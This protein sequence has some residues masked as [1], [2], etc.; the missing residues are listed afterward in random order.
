MTSPLRTRTRLGAAR[1]ANGAKAE[2]LEAL[3]D[4]LEDLILAE[5]FRGLTVDLMAAKLQCSKTTLYAIAPSKEQLVL[6]I[7]KRFFRKA[8]GDVDA[9]VAGI[10]DP[11]TRI[12][13]YLDSVGEAMRKMSAACFEDMIRSEATRDVYDKN[14]RA[15]AEFVRGAIRE[16]IKRKVFRSV[17]A[18]FVGE[19]VSLLIEAIQ[20]GSLLDRTGLSSGDAF[21]E[22]SAVVVGALAAP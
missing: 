22:L 14:S 19:A 10:E 15:A 4:Q 21:A 1:E 12:A 9:S 20:E 6:T 3:R 7:L 5:G 18:A 16:G 17:H 2:R 11:A 13:T 8:A